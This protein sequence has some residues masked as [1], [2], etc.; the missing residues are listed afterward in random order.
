MKF[1]ELA[2]KTEK[3]LRVLMAAKQDRLRVFRFDL[4]SGRVKNVKEARALKKDIARILTKLS[5][6]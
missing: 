1:T 3:E 6:I 2:K 4:A 5:N